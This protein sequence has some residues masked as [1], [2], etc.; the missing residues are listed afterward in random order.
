MDK[1]SDKAAGTPRAKIRRRPPSLVVG[2]GAS[3]GGLAA[4]RSFFDSMPA[5]TGMAFVLVQHLDPDHK[6]MLV[7]LLR[8]HTAMH[9]VEAHDKAPLAANQIHV[10]PPNATL[11]LEGD[12]M[13]VA[14]PAPAR[15]YRRPIDTFLAS[16]ADSLLPLRRTRRTARSESSCPASAATDHWASRRSRSMAASRSPRRSSTTPR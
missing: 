4:F 7:E 1:K 5:D 10:I 16:L 8:P 12:I 2:I 14:V 9:I 15:V 3:A 13:R 6:S 11:T